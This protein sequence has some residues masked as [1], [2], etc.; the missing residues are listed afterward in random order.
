MAEPLAETSQLSDLEYQEHCLQDVSRTFALTIPQLPQNLV[1]VIG[2]AYLLCRIAD[3]IED[4]AGL[5]PARKRFFSERYIAALAGQLD[6]A[7][8]A[9]N[10]VAELSPA[11]SPAERDLI[12]QIP[13][14]LRIRQ[15][16]SARESQLLFDC[17]RTMSRG[18]SRFQA[19]ASDRGLA[20]LADLNSYCYH[21]AGVVGEMLTELFCD[22]SADINSHRQELMQLAVAFGQGLQMTNILKDSRDDFARGISWLPRDVC[23]RHGIDLSKPGQRANSDQFASVISELVAIAHGHLIDALRFTL[24]LPRSETGLR[25]FCLWAIGMALMTLRNIQRRDAFLAGSEVKISRRTVR[26]IILLSDLFVTRD[27]ILSWL[28]RR[29]ASTLPVPIENE[30]NAA[31]LSCEAVRETEQQQ[32]PG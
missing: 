3:T 11:A 14:V 7:E 32:A 25:K 21:V 2:N 15:G 4:D 18:M 13:R 20:T 1:P 5:A 6:T 16:F 12:S 23:A 29:A 8:F 10:L 22:Y 9:R 17:V 19:R 26:G 30:L 31:R 24:L 27:K 28:F